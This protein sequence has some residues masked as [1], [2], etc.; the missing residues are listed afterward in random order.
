MSPISDHRYGCSGID[1]VSFGPSSAT[2]TARASSPVAYGIYANTARSDNDHQVLLQYDITD[3]ARYE[4]P[5]TE[6]APHRGPLPYTENS[7]CANRQHDV[8]RAKPRL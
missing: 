6:A 5:L 1:G 7:S 2:P 4:R 3:W 8:R